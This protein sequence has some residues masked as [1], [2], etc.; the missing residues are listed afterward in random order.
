MR[1]FSKAPDGGKDSGVTGYFIVEIKSLFSIVLLHFSPGSREAY[2][3]HAFNAFTIWLKG[4]AT[5]ETIKI[6]DGGDNDEYY[7]DIWF[8]GNRK[9]TPRDQMHRISGGPKGAWALSF[10]GP[11]TKEW[12]EYKNGEYVTLTHGRKVVNGK[13]ET[14][15]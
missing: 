7:F 15:T 12:K 10:R 9:Y 11:W 8:P 3:S 13:T 4:E 5:E 2:H 6:I 14:G 1:V